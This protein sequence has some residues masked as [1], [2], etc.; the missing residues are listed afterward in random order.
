MFR[1]YL[2]PI[3]KYSIENRTIYIPRFNLN[4][5]KKLVSYRVAKTPIAIMIEPACACN[6][7]CPLCTTPHKYM[8]RKQGIME[9]KTFQKLLNDVKDFVLVFYLNFAGEPFLNPHLFKMVDEAT[10]HNILSLVDTNATLLTDE[11]IREI[12]DSE[13]NILIINVDHIKKDHF[14]NFRKG[15]KFES[16]MQGIKKL[17]EIKKKEKRFFPLVMAEIIVSRENEQHLQDIYDYAINELGVNGAWFKSLC[18]PL[19]SKGFRDDHNIKALVDKYLPLKSSVKRYNYINGDLQ[20]INPKEF[21]DWEHKSLI[22]W[23]GRVSACCY[24]YDGAYTFG[25][26]NNRSFLD[27]WNSKKYRYYRE[28]MI[29]NKKLSICERCSIL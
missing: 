2:L 19:H 22:M 15:A 16:T 8:S 21:C 28:K 18:F 12:L 5:L 1:E 4:T 17:C 9:F 20:L 27:I 14:E 24:D 23:D 3:I 6:I 13:L 11:R 7:Q 29:K 10:K 25:N 26:I